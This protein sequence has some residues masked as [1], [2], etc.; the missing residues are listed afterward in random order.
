MTVLEEIRSRGHLE[1]LIRPVS[2]SSDRIPFD[3]LEETVRRTSV[4]W[5]GWD[6]P[7]VD[8]HSVVRRDIQ[9]IGQESE[10]NHHLEVWRI[11]TS[12]QFISISGFAS[13]WRD[14]SDFWPPDAHWEHGA[15]IGVM[16]V[17]LR[18]VEAFRFAARLSVTKAGDEE[19][20]ISVTTSPLEGRQLVMDD[21]S[22]FMSPGRHQASIMEFPYSVQVEREQLLADPEAFAIAAAQAL[23]L[24]FDWSISDEVLQGALESFNKTL[25]RS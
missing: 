14:R 8:P 12:G 7:H 1:V 23:F 22:R 5:R 21:P 17:L 16:E 20:R 19:M 4:R 3:E 18:Y 24:R 15:T 11:W 13:E 10:W 9:W 6:F 25:G 2:Y